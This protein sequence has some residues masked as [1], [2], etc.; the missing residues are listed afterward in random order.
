MIH[1]MNILTVYTPKDKNKNEKKNAKTKN[2]VKKALPPRRT[3]TSERSLIKH[4]ELLGL[5]TICIL[6]LSCDGASV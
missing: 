3:M 5:Q 1:F 6:G 2:K 4:D